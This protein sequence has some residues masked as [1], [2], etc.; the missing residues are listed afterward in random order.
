MNMRALYRLTKPGVTYGNLITTVAGY[1]FAANG[2]I[3]LQVFSALTIGTWGVIAS[4][5][6]INNYLDQDIDA[7]MTRTKKRP[8]LTG[9]VTPKQA[10]IFGALLGLGGTAV[11]SVF[12]NYW[13]AGI[14]VLGWIVYVWL[15]GAL[16][17]RKSVHGTLVGAVSGAVP[18]W[19]G[20]LAVYPGVDAVGVLLFL[21]IFFWQMPE[22]YAISIFREKEYAEANVPVSSV[23]RGAKVTARQIIIYTVLTVVCTLALVVS[24]L[25]SWTMMVVLIVTCLWWIAIVLPGLSAKNLAAWARKEFHFAL[26]FLVIFCIVLSLN[27]YLP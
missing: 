24:P 5:C 18:I 6:V 3:D 17:K 16:G 25:T 8:L 21:V 14:G 23:V 22:F 10:V 27:P 15:Y 26:I 1:L 20:W 7:V 12:T 11:L 2:S 9:E 4:A 13:V 19:A